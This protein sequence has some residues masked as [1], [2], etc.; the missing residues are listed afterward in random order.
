MY[1]D[2]FI[3]IPLLWGAYKGFRKGFIIE[4]ASLIALG[5][6]LWG[7][8]KFAQN[9]AL[10]LDQWVNISEKLM[11]LLSFAITFIIIVMAVF[12]LAKL[13]ER[14]IKLVALGLV[15]RFAG[16]IFG[17]FKF[18]LITGVFIYFL[19][20]ADIQFSFLSQELKESSLL[21][22][23]FNS[24]IDLVLPELSHLVKRYTFHF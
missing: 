22:E 5:I 13:L 1:L 21:Y 19:N 14:L 2:L 8:I 3:L 15:N 16:S 24:I 9:M 23:P 17:L 11:P 4:L 18:A 7:G 12:A 10:Y 20:I 6:G